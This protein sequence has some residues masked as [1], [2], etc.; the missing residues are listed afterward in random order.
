MRI[1]EVAAQAEVHVQTI[2]FYERRR[3]LKK[4]ARLTS[5]YRSFSPEAVQTIRFIRQSQELG[6]TLDEIKQLLQLREMTSGNADQMRALAK[7]KLRSIED[8]MQSLQRMHDELSSLLD[9]CTCG[10]TQ[11]FCPVLEKLHR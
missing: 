1:G 2:R 4:P 5:G 8:K 3:L 6:F 11:P 10:E 7:A 9:N